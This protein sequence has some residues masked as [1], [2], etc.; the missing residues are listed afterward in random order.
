MHPAHPSQSTTCY[1]PLLFVDWEFASKSGLAYINLF[2][3]FLGS[4]VGQAMDILGHKEGVGDN[5][6]TFVSVITSWTLLGLCVHHFN[7]P[8]AKHGASAVLMS[9]VYQHHRV[10]I[11]RVV[12]KGCQTWVSPGCDQF[13]ICSSPLAFCSKSW[14]EAI[15]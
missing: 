10:S 3:F 7:R 8:W 4:R 5:G 14:I 13:T 12:A 9:D 11:S 1:A 2:R 6:S 15:S